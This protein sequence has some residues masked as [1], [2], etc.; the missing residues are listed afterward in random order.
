MATEYVKEYE[1]RRA[2]GWYAFGEYVAN[3]DGS[4]L[5]FDGE[6]ETGLPLWERPKPKDPSVYQLVIL[7]A[8]AATKKH[9]YAGTVSYREKFRR[10]RKNRVARKSRRLNRAS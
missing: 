5:E 6:D 8:L 3:W 2:Q 4:E 10:R 1:R 7:L 9:I